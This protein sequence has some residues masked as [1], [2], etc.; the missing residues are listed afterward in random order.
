M[1]TVCGVVLAEKPPGRH[2]FSSGMVVIARRRPRSGRSEPG[3]PTGGRAALAA[4]EG[5]FLV[6]V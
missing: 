2:V 6:G 5:M 4:T 3:R 1:G